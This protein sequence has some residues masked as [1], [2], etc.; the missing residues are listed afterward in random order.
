MKVTDPVCGMSLDLENAVAREDY[1]GWTYFF[2]SNACHRLFKNSPERFSE[3]PETAPGPGFRRSM[4]GHARGHGH[5]HW[6]SICWVRPTPHPLCTTLLT[7]IV[8]PI[9]RLAGPLVGDSHD[10]QILAVQRVGGIVLDQQC[11]DG[12]VANANPQACLTPS[13]EGKST[14]CDN[15]VAPSH[16]TLNGPLGPACRCCGERTLLRLRI[17][18]LSIAGGYTH[19]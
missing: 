1:K 7:F 13:R 8:A 16:S 4:Q 5:T 19:P 3:K 10:R 6:R 18:A 12:T 11:T 17:C 14:W 2:C 15:A 9:T